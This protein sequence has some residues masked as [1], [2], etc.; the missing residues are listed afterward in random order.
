MIKIQNVYY[1]L[2]YA[3]SA[4]NK[5]GY[6]KIGTEHFDNIGDLCG[7]ILIR[8][9]TLQIK[10]GLNKE[11]RT[12]V[13]PLVTPKGKIEIAE[14]IKTRSVMKKRLVCSY[15]EFSVNCNQ[16]KILKTTM[17]V[18]LKSDIDKKRKKKLRKLLVYFN[19][20]DCVPIDQI[21]WN[22]RYHRNNQN[23]RLLIG[24]CYLVIHGL[25]QNKEDG[26]QKFMDFDD[27]N[28]AHLY[29]KFVLEYFKKEYPKMKV[30]AP[31]IPWALDDV[32]SDFLPDMRTDITLEYKDR[33]LIIDTKYYGQILKSWK[34]KK[35][36]SSNNL[37]QIYTY[38]KNRQ[39]HLKDE[40]IT[41]SGMLL[42][43]KTDEDITP[44]Q[45]YRM[46]GNS[47]AV[48]TLDLN[49]DFNQ[50]K[51]ELDTIVEEYFKD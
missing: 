29:E 41:V 7:E 2:C 26:F 36:I 3:F 13:D 34:S 49:A 14:S 40:G 12:E 4:L 23:Y 17:M 5:Q 39:S 9:I 33:I 11:Y 50:I 35:T 20:I 15:D 47:I 16:N 38:V 32:E 25:I 44:N 6:K 1:M 31:R 27:E 24:V 19:E 42:Y 30:H 21:D 22:I 45:T 51:Q 37:Y 28:K 10:Q 8:G 18:L 43:A 48:R 46:D